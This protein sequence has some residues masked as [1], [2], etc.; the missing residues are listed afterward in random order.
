VTAGWL[1]LARLLISPKGL[2]K[3]KPGMGFD[4]GGFIKGNTIVRCALVGEL[5]P[6]ASWAT[7]QYDRR[8]KGRFINLLLFG[9]P[10][11][12]FSDFMQ[13]ALQAL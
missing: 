2:E 8:E 4:S 1:R 5:P 7:Y 6:S 9:L 13:M 12:G 3:I 11:C 10:R